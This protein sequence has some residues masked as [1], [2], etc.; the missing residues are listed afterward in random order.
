MLIILELFQGIAKRM[1]WYVICIIQDQK[2]NEKPEY[3][4]IQKAKRGKE[5]YEDCCKLIS[6]LPIHYS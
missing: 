2:L 1:M 5:K 4:E 3:G 6:K